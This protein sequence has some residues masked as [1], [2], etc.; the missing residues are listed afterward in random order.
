VTG[1]GSASLPDPGDGP[2]AAGPRYALMARLPALEEPLSSPAAIAFQMLTTQTLIPQLEMGRR[3]VAIC[4]ASLGVGVTFTAVNLALILS[5]AGVST[6]LLDANLHGPG[7]DEVIAPE[8]QGPG[9]RQLLESDETAMVDA[10]HY[11]VLPNLSVLYAGGSTKSA[12]ELLATARLEAILRDCLRSFSYTIIDTP[13]GNRT[14]DALRTAS[15]IGYGLVVARRN[16]SYVD[17]VSTLADQLRAD[18]VELI[19]TLVNAV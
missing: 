2:D 11:D 15:I 9:L 5:R 14:S 1:T 12:S 7:I 13:P 4:G 10:I 18:G 6:L 17:D 19:G 16:L 8:Q 3:G